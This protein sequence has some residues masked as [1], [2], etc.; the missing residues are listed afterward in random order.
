M[1]NDEQKESYAKNARSILRTLRVEIQQIE[2]SAV[3]SRDGLIIASLMGDD[4]DEDRFGAMCASL[5]AL[6]SKATLEVDRGELR[7][8]ILDGSK[9]PVLLTYC[10][11]ISVLAVAAN[12]KTNLGRLIVETRKVAQKLAHV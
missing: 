8:V 9:G 3:I 7:Q 6:S 5:V 1:F 2:A 12:P 10:G 4:V 11:A